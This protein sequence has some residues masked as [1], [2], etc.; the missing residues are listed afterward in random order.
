MA[1]FKPITSLISFY[2]SS[3]LHG[4]SHLIRPYLILNTIAGVSPCFLFPFVDNPWYYV[5]AYSI[6]MITRKAKEPAWIEYLKGHLELP[7]MSK[8]ISRG[9]SIAY[10]IGMFLPPLLSLW[11]DDELWKIL[12]LISAILQSLNVIN[13]LYLKPKVSEKIETPNLPYHQKI[14]DPLRKGYQLLKQNPGFSHYLALFFLGGAGIIAIQPILPKYFD[15]TLGLSYTQLTLAFSFCKGISYLV[16]S[17]IW[18]KYAT[19]ISLY[20][21]NALMNIL[22]C[23]FIGGIMAASF[24]T[25]WLYVA[26]LCYGAMMGGCELSYSLSG[27]IFSKQGDSAPYSSLNLILVGIRGCICPFLGT[28]IFTYGGANAVFITAFATC[29]IGVFYGLW[30]D[31]KYRSHKI[32]ELA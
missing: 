8:I 28:L 7:Q 25:E 30:L 13:I 3:T 17:P 11:L 26:Y 5:L 21:I 24:G 4:R 29:I 23:F 15:N 20:R 31:I 22:T 2:V 12:F 18:A 27:P 19:K 32:P 1:S 10:F 6:Y 9:T 14:I 16:S